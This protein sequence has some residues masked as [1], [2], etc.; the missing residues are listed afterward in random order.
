MTTEIDPPFHL[1]LLDW[2]A[3]GATATMVIAARD[4]ITGAGIEAL[5]RAGGH[6]VVARC[7]DED[8][9]LRC[10]EACGPDIVMLEERVGQDSAKTISRL[11][12][13]KR[14]A[15]IFLLKESDAIKIAGLL[16]LDVDGI[17]LSGARARRLIDCVESVAHGQTW[18]DPGL[19]RHLVTA[20]PCPL[21][22][23]RLT[24]RER[25]IAQLVAR[26]LSNK[27]IARELHLS[28]GT[29]KMHLHHIYEKFGLGGRMQLALSIAGACTQMPVSG[30][31]TVPARE[32]AYLD[33][34]AAVR[35]V[36]QRKPKN[37]A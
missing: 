31:E 17:L 27:A 1:R 23:S 25:N 21:T 11:R 24:S 20:E 7:L 10:S 26:G 9:L 14:A 32:P 19:V 13:R 6:R 36:A 28:E 16:D 15:I 35:V 12:A 18:V 37:L 2:P 34:A 8:D 3:R 33:C 30:N 4:E 5:L 29:V 22:V